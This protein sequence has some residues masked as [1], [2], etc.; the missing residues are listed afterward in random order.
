VFVVVLSGRI[1]I[2]SAA[3]L[4]FPPP[5]PGLSAVIVLNYYGESSA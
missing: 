1:E 3:L 4:S 2:S 5:S